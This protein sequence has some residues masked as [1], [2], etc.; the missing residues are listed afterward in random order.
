MIEVHIYSRWWVS[1]NIKG[2]EGVLICP[3]VSGREATMV[4]GQGVTKRSQDLVRQAAVAA[5]DED[6]DVMV[7]TQ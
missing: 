3:G 7:G 6:I 2:F 5:R 1:A 4:F